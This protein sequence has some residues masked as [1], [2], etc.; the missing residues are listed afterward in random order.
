LADATVAPAQGQPLSGRGRLLSVESTDGVS[1]AVHELGPSASGPPLLISHATGFCGHAYAPIALALGDRFHTLAMDHRG[2]GATRPPPGW[3]SGRD[4]DWRRFGDDTLAV[5]RAIDGRGQLVGFGHSM[6]G[7]SLLMAAHRD[8]SLFARLVLFEPIARPA[9]DETIDASGWPIVVGARRRKPVFPSFQAAF[10]N[11]DRKMPLSLM[12]AESLLGYVEHGLR[13]TSDGQV[14]LCCPPELEAA[15]FELGPHNCVWDL[16]AEID[17]PVL[18]VAGAYEPD[19]PSATAIEI[20]E[21]LPRG[22]LLVLPEQG[23]LGPFS[24]PHE[25]AGVISAFM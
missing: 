24:H 13:P 23:H 2:H 15:I 20:A 22:E 6:G 4:V 25:V 5:A 8:P 19:Q 12:T 7:A 1:V 16:L 17:M 18:V 3:E 10:D 11:F 9:T 21:E 14:E